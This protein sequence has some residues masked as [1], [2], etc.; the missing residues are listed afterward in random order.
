MKDGKYVETFEQLICSYIL[1]FYAIIIS[2]YDGRFSSNNMQSYLEGLTRRKKYIYISQNGTIYICHHVCG[3][4]LI[5]C[6]DLVQANH[7]AYLHPVSDN[8]FSIEPNTIREIITWS[9]KGYPDTASHL[10]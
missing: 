2:N 3:S 5:R 9:Q 4:P 7:F 1:N 10:L 8:S 6:T